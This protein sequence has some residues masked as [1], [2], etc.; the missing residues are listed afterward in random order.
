L[1]TVGESNKKF[2]DYILKND[3][4]LKRDLVVA[5]YKSE[6]SLETVVENIMNG[7]NYQSDNIFSHLDSRSFSPISTRYGSSA[8][9][10]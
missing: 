5:M 1:V 7:K 3:K 4:S 2:R 8:V 10:F 6:E 9:G